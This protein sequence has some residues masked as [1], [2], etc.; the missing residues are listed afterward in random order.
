MSEVDYDASLQLAERLV[1]FRKTRYITPTGALHS[2]L[3][4]ERDIRLM[5]NQLPRI[6]LIGCGKMGGAMLSGWLD[7]GVEKV[8]VVAP[9]PH[10]VGF[11]DNR[12]LVCRN[13]TEI[14][15]SFSPSVVVFAVKPQVATQILTEYRRYAVA[16]TVFLSIMAGFTT[17]SLVEA[18]GEN[19]C[20][21]RAMPNSPA[22]I[23]QGFT[24]AFAGSGI[25]EEHKHL[26]NDLLEAVGEV[27]WVEDETLLDPATAISGGGPAYVYLL[28]EMLQAA[29]VDQG[30]PNAIAERMARATVAGSGALL[31]GSDVDAAQLRKNVTS[32]GGTT[33][34]ALSVL[35]HA[36]AWPK[37]VSDAIC[38]ATARSKELS[39]SQ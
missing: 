27:A 11:T 4:T 18:L 33:E 34:R 28:V 32:P 36:G 39:G 3:R 12:V 13:M 24:V 25:A 22:A 7:R 21:V 16:G 35:M 37:S 20:V 26:F 2:S 30:I 6:L 15:T 17:Q 5:A 38:A 19:T 8:V 31:A 10:Q 29:A 1:R 9:R 14:P 23:R